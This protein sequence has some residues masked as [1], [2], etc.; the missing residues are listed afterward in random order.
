MIKCAESSLTNRGHGS[1]YSYKFSY[2][3]LQRKVNFVFFVTVKFVYIL[4]YLYMHK[5]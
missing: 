5:L 3:L 1:K 4:K 2:T